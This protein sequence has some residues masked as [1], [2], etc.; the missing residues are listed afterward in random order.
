MIRAFRS[1]LLIT[2]SVSHPVA[3]RL[4]DIFAA[5]DMF[6][7]MRY[8]GEAHVVPVALRGDVALDDLLGIETQK[9]AFLANIERFLSGAPYQHTLLWGARGTGK[10][11]LVRAALRFFRPRGLKC[12]QVACDDLPDL[13]FLLWTLAQVPSPFVVFIDDLSFG[14]DDGS[15]RALK[16]VLDGALGGVAANV[17]ICLTSN[18]RHLLAEFH[19][20]DRALH[21]QE[22][23]E[24]QV[25][26]AERFGLR[27]AF[28]PLDQAQFLVTVAHWL[29]RDLSPDERQRALQFALAQGSRSARVAAQCAQ[30]LS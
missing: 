17:L 8:Q 7:R 15:Y 27:L 20:D 1:H 2:M 21:P 5:G 16:A 29:G 19:R 28:H 23:V 11:S 10:S 26:L 6:V 18:R 12:L 13:P 9:A 3:A 4:L 25:S 14:A 30:A 22:D 24:E